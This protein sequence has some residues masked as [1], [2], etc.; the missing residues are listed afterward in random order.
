MLP[1]RRD[2]IHRLVCGV[3]QHRL[4]VIYR[5]WSSWTVRLPSWLLR[6]GCHQ[7][8][9]VRVPVPQWSLPSHS[10]SLP[11]FKVRLQNPHDESNEGCDGQ[12]TDDDSFVHVCSNC[13]SFV[14]KLEARPIPFS[15]WADIVNGA[16]NRMVLVGHL[17]QGWC[18]M[19]RWKL[20]PQ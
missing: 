11:L 1:Y 15:R 20:A 14:G 18:W 8:A 2:I 10:P 3:L 5:R 17:G 12:Q 7:G 13:R 4:V 9:D 19:Y 16:I 6:V